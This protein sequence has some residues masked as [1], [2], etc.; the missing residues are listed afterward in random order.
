[1]TRLAAL[2]WEYNKALEGGS[3]NIGEILEAMLDEYS[4]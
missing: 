1:M 4:I 3:G 2:Q